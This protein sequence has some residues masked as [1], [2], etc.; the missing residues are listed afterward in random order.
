M[1]IKYFYKGTEV[2]LVPGQQYNTYWNVYYPDRNGKRII[3]I[4]PDE[5]LQIVDENLSSTQTVFPSEAS[6]S[7]RGVKGQK[8][9]ILPLHSQREKNG[10]A[11][12]KK[13]VMQPLESKATAT[14]GSE[15]TKATVRT[16]DNPN[17]SSETT[18]LKSLEEVAEDG[19]KDKRVSAT[20]KV[21]INNIENNSS[22]IHFLSKELPG[23]GRKAA[24]VILENK[25]DN[26]YLDAKS[27][28]AINEVHLD[29]VNFDSVIDL[30][31]F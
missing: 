25:P 15:D 10:K 6:S 19:K 4:R 1:G 14:S 17:L 3:S 26:G 16:K 22:G 9:D 30:L 23:V 8:A 27:F 13:A 5:D 18:R 20:N 24:T 28:V 2:Q 31:E 7:P 21:L 11:L 12:G 29:Y